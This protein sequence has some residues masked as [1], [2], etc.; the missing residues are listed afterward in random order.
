MWEGEAPTS[1][2]ESYMQARTHRH[3][4]ILQMLMRVCGCYHGPVA[5]LKCWAPGVT[6]KICEC[7]AT[8]MHTVAW[9]S[10]LIKGYRPDGTMWGRG[11]CGDLISSLFI[12]IYMYMY[13]Y[14]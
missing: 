9:D 13:R 1:G 2:L 12:Y 5:D 6:F 8:H 11:P 10:L 14:V 3:P 4:P 7:N